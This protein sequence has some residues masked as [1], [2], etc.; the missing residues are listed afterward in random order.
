MSAQL[1]HPLRAGVL[2]LLPLALLAATTAAQ[3]ED[4]DA[5]TAELSPGTIRVESPGIRVTARLNRDVGE[6]TAVDG[7]GDSGV[8]LATPAELELMAR[9][10]G[11]DPG[12]LEPIARSN[13]GT[14]V[15][16]WLNTEDAEP[17][18]YTITLEGETGACSSDITID[19]LQA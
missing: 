17:G 6:I 14:T 1:A 10:S 19:G 11:R 7:S 5:C 12:R 9:T 16:L 2:G 15:T 3:Q 18:R 8:R 4:P 13:D